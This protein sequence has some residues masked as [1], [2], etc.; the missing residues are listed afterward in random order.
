MKKIMLFMFLVMGAIH[1]Q[2]Q[3]SSNDLIQGDGGTK[4]VIQK[5]LTTIA[6]DEEVSS[7]NVLF[8]NAESECRIESTAGEIK[9]GTVFQLGYIYNSNSDPQTTVELISQ[10]ETIKASIECVN[11][12][13]KGI[14]YY[15]SALGEALLMQN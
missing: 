4:I 7:I 14:S 10:D 6:Q 2:A 15:N 12:N 8:N 13:E 3:F 5:D 1:A 11:G 9:K